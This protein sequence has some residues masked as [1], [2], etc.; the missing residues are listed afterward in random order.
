MK[1]FDITRK[2]DGLIFCIFKAKWYTADIEIKLWIDVSYLPLSIKIEMTKERTNANTFI[3]ISEGVQSPWRLAAK[4]GTGPLPS[5]NSTTMGSSFQTQFFRGYI[6]LIVFQ[7]TYKTWCNVE[8][9][10][11]ITIWRHVKDSSLF[12]VL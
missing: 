9:S 12:F 6:T 10:L 4:R 1:T 2:L 7:P 11:F 8:V 5:R 3:A